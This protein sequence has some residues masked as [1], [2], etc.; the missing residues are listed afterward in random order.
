MGAAGRQRRPEAAPVAAAALR[1]TRLGRPSAAAQ[2]VVYVLELLCSAALS[3]MAAGGGRQ[4][5]WLLRETP[6]RPVGL[7][8]GLRQHV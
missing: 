6:F 8:K 3:E 4:Q 2:R 5:E 1:R 7:Q